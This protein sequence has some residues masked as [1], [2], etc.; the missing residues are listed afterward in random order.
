MQCVVPN[1]VIY[2]PGPMQSGIV[3]LK[4]SPI[5]PMAC[6][7]EDVERYLCMPCLSGCLAPGRGE[8]YRLFI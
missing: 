5:T 4:N 6:S 7:T 2:D 1:K 8:L 3:V